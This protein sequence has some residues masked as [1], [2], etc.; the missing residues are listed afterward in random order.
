[1]LRAPVVVSL[2]TDYGLADGFVGALHSVLRRSVPNVPIVDIS[3]LVPAQDVRAG[4][5]ALRRAAPYLAPGVVVAVVDPG[6]GTERR[7]VA[8]EV[9]VGPAPGRTGGFIF[10]GP[11]NGLLVPAADAL[12]GAGRAV[13]LENTGYWLEAPGPTFAGRDI[14]APAA[15]RIAEGG[16]LLSLGPPISPATLVRLPGPLCRRHPGAEL[17]VEVTWVDRYGNVQLAAGPALL[18]APGEVAVSRPPATD[19]DTGA[20]ASWLAR[21][22]TAF[23]DL[24]ADELGLLVDSYGYLSLCLNAAGAAGALGLREGDVVWLRG[25]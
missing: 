19:D 12:G 6:V 15:A 17:E 13:E 5:L 22:V 18:P 14:F 24:Q 20:R 4:S 8:L 7:A 16:D 11:D 25:P 23:G 2:L 21:V 10:I 1:M 9:A 3:H